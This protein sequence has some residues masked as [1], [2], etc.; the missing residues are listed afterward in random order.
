MSGTR[1]LSRSFAGGEITPELFGRIDLDKMQTGLMKCL[2]MIIRPHGPAKSRGGFRFLN[3]CKFNDRK[4][5]LIKFQ[6][7]TED[8]MI[9]EMGH[10]YAR[11]HTNLGTELDVDR[12]I[13]S[14][15]DDGGRVLVTVN[16]ASA[17]AY[18]NLGA[19]NETFYIAE[20]HASVNG[21]Y[22][23][24]D[25]QSS[26]SFHLMDQLGNYI[27]PASLTLPISVPA[28]AKCYKVYE[29]VTPYDE[30][31]L[32]D[33]RYVQ[34]LDVMTFTHPDYPAA[35]LS[36][37]LAGDVV[38]WAYEVIDFDPASILEI[39]TGLSATV[40]GSEHPAASRYSY[41][42]TAISDD[43]HEES[44][45]S[46][47]NKEA[48]GDT[49]NKISDVV[50]WQDLYDG[51]SPTVDLP[52]ADQ[53]NYAVFN[54]VDTASLLVEGDEVVLTDMPA[55][56][57]DL[58]GELFTVETVVHSN[59]RRYTLLDNNGDPVR[60]S[61]RATFVTGPSHCREC[62]V[63]ADLSHEGNA[64]RLKWTRVAGISRYNV[65]KRQGVSNYY[66]YVGQTRSPRF[67]D[68][69]IIA[70]LTKSPPE[71][72]NYFA[73]DNPAA[74]T[75]FDQRKLFAGTSNRPQTVWL[76]KPYTE[77]NISSSFPVRPDDSIMITAKT[78][79]AS[80][81][82]HA[83]SLND[84]VLLTSGG[85]IR[86]RAEGDV[87]TP[88]TASAKAQSYIGAATVQPVMSN[89]A[90]I[91]VENGG[92]ALR[93]LVYK[94]DVENSYEAQNISVM[95]PH[96]F[97]SPIVDLAFQRGSE[98]VIWAV[99]DDGVLVG[100]T[101]MPE[102]RVIAYHQHDTN[103]LFESIATAYS[104]VVTTAVVPVNT[105]EEP[106]EADNLVAKMSLG[107]NQVDGSVPA[108][109]VSGITWTATGSAAISSNKLSVSSGGYIQSGQSGFEIGTNEFQFSFKFNGTISST[110][111]IVSVTN[112]GISS[113]DPIEFS[114]EITGT[115]L[116]FYHGVRGTWQS[117]LLMF[118]TFSS[119][120]DYT[121]EFGRHVNGDW[122]CIVNDEET[123]QYQWAPP[124]AT[125]N[126]GSITT[127]TFN[128]LTDIGW[129]TDPHPMTIGQFN[130]GY[131]QFTGDIDY[132][133][134][135]VGTS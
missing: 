41:A 91:F 62:G 114:V 123:T 7:S 49:T 96:L 88:T 25:V 92:N 11:F 125:I 26:S 18:A 33:L 81:I 8:S 102:Q 110:H 24:A 98:P 106:F 14:I 112:T 15:I 69:N 129:R 131:F 71:G 3:F 104:A 68:K 6:F 54:I 103:G 48:L 115:Y 89:R 85:E 116:K 53:S 83:V 109:S 130:S 108:D 132:I 38:S 36:R 42:V 74:V 73:D 1:T 76:T 78:N 21:R 75:Y 128:S 97:E 121:V 90:A 94:G 32:F 99:R 35:T 52:T 113:G 77:S 70:D 5:R 19:N 72:S 58:E 120:T 29:V 93:E 60:T 2:N 133:S 105:D 39:P 17:G 10:L 127:G 57:E 51:G 122:Y 111:C 126:Y 12:P 4:A 27:D 23:N 118:A 55:G 22:F 47:P 28:T 59:S 124:D 50:S 16:P 82:L 65:Y 134:L 79:E 135:S 46:V 13:T 87:L 80:T 30:A 56:W 20:T 84:I 43:G 37:S 9:I 44:L 67:T 40:Q 66:G 100:A 45:P 61:G 34:S 95:A 101:Y 31:D 86:I 119:G 63:M 64:I 107:F 117:S